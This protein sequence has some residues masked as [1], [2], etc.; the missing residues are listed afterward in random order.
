MYVL[1]PSVFNSPLFETEFNFFYISDEFCFNS[2]IKK[3]IYILIASSKKFE[4]DCIII[5]IL[6][7][8]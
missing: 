8:T 5:K 4:L 2:L 1:L 7:N 3:N 6:I